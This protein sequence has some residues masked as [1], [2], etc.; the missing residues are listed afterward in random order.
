MGSDTQR[1][2]GEVDDEIESE[3]PSRYEFFKLTVKDQLPISSLVALKTAIGLIATTEPQRRF[4]IRISSGALT[5]QAMKNKK[6]S[7]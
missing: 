7:Y 5:G 2:D 3:I 6:S 1:D 4:G